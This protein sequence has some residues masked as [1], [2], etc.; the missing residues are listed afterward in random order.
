MSELG[1]CSVFRTIRLVVN[2]DP[3]EVQVGGP[4]EG[5]SNEAKKEK[6]RDAGA[7]EHEE[8]KILG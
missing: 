6:K 2:G 1:P 4:S 5:P 7:V 3:C 8:K